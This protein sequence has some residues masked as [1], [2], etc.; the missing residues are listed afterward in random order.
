MAHQRE[1]DVVVV[2]LESDAQA[3]LRALHLVLARRKLAAVRS[4]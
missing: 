2:L 3:R 4:A 1:R